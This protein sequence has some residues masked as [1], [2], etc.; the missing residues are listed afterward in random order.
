MY[1]YKKII[2]VTEKIPN[3]KGQQYEVQSRSNA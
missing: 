2:Q 1:E 3:N